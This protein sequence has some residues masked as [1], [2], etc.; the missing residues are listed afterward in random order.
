VTPRNTAAIP[1]IMVRVI[2]IERFNIS[3]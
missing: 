1:F 2:S 3:G